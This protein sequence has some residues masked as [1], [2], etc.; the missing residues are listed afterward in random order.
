VKLYDVANFYLYTINS[1]AAAGWGKLWVDYEFDFETPQIPA[2]GSNFQ[3]SI[4]I[5][6]GGT[7]SASGGKVANLGTAPTMV[8]GLQAVISTTGGNESHIVLNGLTVGAE[9]LISSDVICP[10]SD[11][12]TGDTFNTFV[13]AGIVSNNSTINSG[14]TNVVSFCT[15]VP[16]ASTV[17][18]NYYGSG[19]ALTSSNMVITLIPTFVP[20]F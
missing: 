3:N 8:G 2:A 20:A 9:Y 11:L 12:T 5:T 13:G 7:F 1:A 18:F 19:T 6:G 17:S 16:T 14:Q 15:F 4:A 10:G